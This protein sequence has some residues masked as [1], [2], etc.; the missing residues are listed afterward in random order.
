MLPPASKSG[1]WGGGPGRRLSPPWPSGRRVLSPVVWRGRWALLWALPALPQPQLAGPQPAPCLPAPLWPQG[2]QPSY[3]FSPQ[4]GP[5]PDCLP[6]WSWPSRAF[7]DPCPGRT[8]VSP[9]PLA[10]SDDL[11]PVQGFQ[12]CIFSTLPV[13]SFL[14]CQV[15]MLKKNEYTIIHCATTLKQKYF[16]RWD[17]IT[18]EKTVFQIE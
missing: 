4:G 18:E 13:A 11:R 9:G 8:C 6:C 10:F 17:L 7:H 3:P 14:F 12:V 2:P 1:P 5:W 15:R 16:S